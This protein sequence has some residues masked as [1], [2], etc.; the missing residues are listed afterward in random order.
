MRCQKR[1]YLPPK[2]EYTVFCQL[3]DMQKNIY[4]RLTG[5]IK[6]NCPSTT[7]GALPLITSLKKL[8]NCPELIHPSS[9]GTKKAAKGKGKEGDD[10]DTGGA[11]PFSI[12]S[13]IYPHTFNP[14]TWQP[15]YSGNYPI[16]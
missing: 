11:I 10:E 9:S 5:D 6:S 12:I 15:Q 2:T 4:K 1:R 7:A 3:T 14:A 13:D 8:C 16:L